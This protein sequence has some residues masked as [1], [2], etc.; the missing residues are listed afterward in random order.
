MMTTFQ[1]DGQYLKDSN[2]Q[3]I[4]HVTPI[5]SATQMQAGVYVKTGGAAG[6]ETVDVDRVYFSQNR[7]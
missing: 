6:G 2:G 7:I 5:A 3:T 1:V 4:R